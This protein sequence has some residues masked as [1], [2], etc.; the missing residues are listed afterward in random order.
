MYNNIIDFH[1]HI[2][3]EKIA[4]KA[5]SAIKDFYDGTMQ[6]NGTVEELLASG[7]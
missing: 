1:A 2:Y 4:K 3:P 6:Y 7:E 5:S